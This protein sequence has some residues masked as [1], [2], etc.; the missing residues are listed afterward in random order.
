M[1]QKDCDCS[2]STIE[3]LV[4][5]QKCSKY[6]FELSKGEVEISNELDLIEYCIDAAQIF[7]VKYQHPHWMWNDESHCTAHK[8]F[9]MT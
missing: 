9:T 4:L 7:P 8:S 5:D 1:V 6:S 3:M 2:M